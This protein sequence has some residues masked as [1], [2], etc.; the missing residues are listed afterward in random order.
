MRKLIKIF[1][2]GF[3]ISFQQTYSG[4]NEYNIESFSLPNGISQNLIYTIYQ[5]SKG[6]IWFGSMFGLVRYDGSNTVTFRYNPSDTTSLSNDDVISIYEDN[7]GIIWIGTYKGGLNSYDRTTGLFSRYIHKENYKNTISD[8]TVWAIYQ[9]KNSIIWLGTEGGLNKLE[10]GKFTVY[11]HD[12]ANIETIA[13]NTIF[14]ITED[15]INNLWLGTAFGGLNKMDRNK[16]TFTSYKRNLTDSNSI[17]GN[18]IRSLYADDNGILWIGTLQKGLNSFNPETGEFKKFVSNPANKN[19]LSNNSI[20][21]IIPGPLGA[22]WI[23]TAN[24]VNKLDMSSGRFINY[25]LVTPLNE[26]SPVAN[27]IC[28][29]N[30][31]IIWT[32]L[33]N[34]G[35]YKIYRNY[36]KLTSYKHIPG[37]NNSLSG[38]EVLSV[39]EDS[40]GQVWIGTQNGLNKF[41][42]PGS[43]FI[44]FQN[45]NTDKNIPGNG[46]S[47]SALFEESNGNFLAGTSAGLFSFDTHKNSFEPYYD[48]SAPDILKQSNITKI[49]EA[50]DKSLWFGTGS[51]IIKYT[52]DINKYELFSNNPKDSNS[53]S[54]D[55]ILSIYEDKN[56]DIWIGTYTGVNKIEN[57]SGKITH[58][59]Q[60]PYNS[61]SISNNYAFC[62]AEDNENNLWIG[63]GGGLNK[64]DKQNGTFTYFTEKDGLPNSVIC[65]LETDNDGNLWISTHNGISK[66]IVK[67]NTFKNYDISDGL[68]GNLFTPGVE[69][70]RK[71]S[72]LV[73]GGTDGFN[74]FNPL[75]MSENKFIPPVVFTSLTKFSGNNKEIRDISGTNNINLS[76]R[77]N[78]IEIQYASL[79]YTNPA[80][81]QYAYILEGFEDA[82]HYAGN[83][84]KAVF[85]NLNPGT[86]IF[87]VKGTNSDGVWN[88]AGNTI[89]I[90]IDPPFWKTWWFYLLVILSI[91][92]LG[93]GSYNYRVKQQVKALLD[94]E[95]AKEIEREKV[96]EQA[97]RDYHDELGHKL[98][99]I[100]IYTR[101]IKKK[102]GAS[103]N[104]LTHDLESIVDTSNSL[105]S[106]A[107][108]LIWSLNPQEDTLYDLAVRLKDFG[109]SLFENSGITFFMDEI[110]GSY[111]DTSLTMNSKRHLVY[112]FK[113]GM[114]NILKYSNSTSVTLHLNYENGSFTI[115][116]EDNGVGFDNNNNSKGYGLK[117]IA[118]RTKQING[119][120]NIISVR[121][122]GTTIKLVTKL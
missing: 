43:S 56:R 57:T 23:A 95:M 50:S 98:T 106:G 78:M 13:S 97:S 121:N 111:K 86:Y 79:D 107:K 2:L 26:T 120:V 93:T 21:A 82:W 103:A 110:P 113:E 46:N 36:N 84:T 94:I 15:K 75:S 22:M 112:I 5:D 29:D 76:Y 89:T 116:L 51:G 83:S 8:N 6:F 104:G 102:L 10:N 25:N 44:S 3:L 49:M 32:T 119:T 9:D 87:R 92:S 14:A 20:L 114:N 39:F 74:I 28:M 99:R 58:Y 33:Y 11:S 31:G 108:D 115:T 69:I 67:T 70:K 27:S 47:I 37:N 72:E 4:S 77:D 65:G 1:A 59:K 53:I 24:G 64:L 122:K 91:F 62:F 40:H 96:R 54:S 61:H 12:S 34:N 85:T 118:V 55:Y 88:E 73:F 80:K 105:Q 90:K 60:N 66:F 100:S 42:E 117:N 45:N 68:Q 109:N 38:G 63:T 16:G 19:S 71:N 35:L 48:S 7:R 30:S 81:N 17:S 52:R 18:Y 41:E 101:R